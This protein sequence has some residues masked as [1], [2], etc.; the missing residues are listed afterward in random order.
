MTSEGLNGKPLI[1]EGTYE[2]RIACNLMSESGAVPYSL[3]IG[4]GSQLDPIHPYFTQS[5]EDREDCPD[6]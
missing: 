4:E 6:Q 2:A 1:A 3:P 5:G